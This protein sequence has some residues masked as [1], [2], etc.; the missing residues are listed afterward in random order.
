MKIRKTMLRKVKKELKMMK[1]SKI[2]F[3]KKN[4]MQRIFVMS[5][6]RQNPT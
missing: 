5:M 2:S 3:R 1:K 6:K 4:K